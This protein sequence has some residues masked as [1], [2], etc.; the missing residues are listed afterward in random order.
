MTGSSKGL[1]TNLIKQRTPVRT[2]ATSQPAFAKALGIV[3]APTPIIKLKIYVKATWKDKGENEKMFY[4][5][6]QK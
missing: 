6:D 5:F 1:Y 2:V 4:V 3:S